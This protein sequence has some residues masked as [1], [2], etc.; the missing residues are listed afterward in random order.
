MAAVRIRELDFEQQRQQAGQTVLGMDRVRAQSHEAMPAR[1][2]RMFGLR[3][4]VASRSVWQRVQALQRNKHFC[5][6]H[7]A[8]RARLDADQPPHFPLGTTAMWHLIDPR[9]RYT[10]PPKVDLNQR[11]ATGALVFH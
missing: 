8:A 9:Y 7:A 3:P 5:V 10:K 6:A 2:H 1:R 11:D 4:H